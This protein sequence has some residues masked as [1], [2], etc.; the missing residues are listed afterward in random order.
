MAFQ[1]RD[2]SGVLFKNDKD[3]VESRPDYR[4]T[5]TIDG[6][7]LEIAAWIKEGKNGKF[8]SLSFQPK[9]AREPAPQVNRAP[10]RDTRTHGER[11]RPSPQT[12]DDVDSDISF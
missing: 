7:E 5:A 2:M 6:E 4:G 12:F 10:Q 8:M 1:Q 9:E 3:G 11:K